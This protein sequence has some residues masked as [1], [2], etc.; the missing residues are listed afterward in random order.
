MRR[1]ALAIAI[2]LVALVLSIYLVPLPARLSE[3]PST[4][5]EFRDGSTAHVFLSPD[6]KWRAPVALDQVDPA[7]VEALIR[8]EDR[9]FRW[10]PGIDPIAIARAAFTNLLSGRRVSGGSTIT[11]QLDRVLEPRPRT[12][13]TK[14]IE[15]FRALQLEARMSKDEILTA[16]LQFVPYGRNVEGIE[17]ASLAYFGHRA[18]SLSPAEIAT[19]L[20]VPQNPNRRFPSA[21]NAAR[22][23]E[24]RNGIAERLLAQG[25]LRDGSARAGAA[26]GRRSPSLEAR[27]A[28]PRVPPEVTLR[29]VRGTPV[30]VSLQAF[31]RAAPHAA[32]WL[33][34]RHPGRTRIRSTLDRG[35][36]ALAE[37]TIAG[38]RDEYAR[39]GIHNAAVV[40]VDHGAA[41]VRALVGG[42]DFWDADH[43]GQIAAFAVPRS[44]GSAL[45][46]FLYAAAID[47]GSAL[48]GFLVPDV[49]AVYGT[50][51]PRN[52]DGSFEGLV[53]LEDALSRSL[54]LPFVSLLRDQGTESFL[55]SLRR[56][57]VT[58]LVS[59]PGHYGL[60]AAVGGLEV[61]PFELAGLYATLAR[62]GDHRE[63]S[64]VVD[65]PVTRGDRPGSESPG[66]GEVFSPG[67]AWLTRQALEIRD[68]PDF[69]ARRRLSGLPADVHWK[70]GTSF[71][72][73]DAWAAGSGPRYT[74]IVWTGN[75][76]N[77]ASVELTGSEAAGP[78]LFDLLEAVADR[79]RP[80][81]RARAPADLTTIEVCAYSGHPPNAACGERRIAPAR[82]TSVPTA[83]CPFHVEVDVERESGLALNAACRGGRDYVRRSFVR[84]PAGVRR[85]LK[86]QRRAVEELPAVHPSCEHGGVVRTAPQIVSPVLGQVAL[87]LDGVDPADQEIPLEAESS[88]DGLLHWFV[89][90]ELVGSVRSDERLWWR[91][92]PG[93][94]EL[95]V[96]DDGGRVARASFEVRRRLQ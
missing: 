35:A 30:P 15:S 48:P 52:F 83:T 62:G 91:P 88:A 50:Y 14:L 10:H 80:P 56:M 74:A 25:A 66:G 6:E 61:T 17:S 81:Q 85:W 63:L 4:V 82:R 90:G 79:G 23:E 84:W 92:T 78:I 46:P 8:L 57:G 2:P 89:D 94:H 40:L 68:R 60:S 65:E 87:L 73:R 76:D 37:R 18:T 43:G 13:R 54:N 59:E 64:T 75:L 93:R 31:P 39:R 69:P 27:L 11:M 86:D 9:R 21:A 16:Y 77:A 1:L 5:V 28:S 72:H 7:Y 3:P 19:L 96:S 33:R 41:Q 58:S 47:R 42:F 12:L 38:L 70:T 32:V 29:G 53:T 44:P 51:A 55:A 24:A 95:V 71:G 20:A 34:A 67:A 49:P 26:S 22:L 45:K 36:Q